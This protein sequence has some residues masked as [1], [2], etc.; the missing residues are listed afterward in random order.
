MGL[1]PDFVATGTDCYS[2]LNSYTS[3]TQDAWIGSDGCLEVKCPYTPQEHLRTV[4]ENQVPSQYVAQVYGHLLVSGRDWCDFVSFDPRI[5]DGDGGLHVIRV[6]RN[7]TFISNLKARI[8][9]A[10]EYV[11]RIIAKC[12]Q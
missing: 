6:E 8:D 9:L 3:G 4:F 1:N 11:G 5:G 12:K 2:E 7:E 10:N